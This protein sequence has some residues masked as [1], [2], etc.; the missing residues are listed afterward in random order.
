MTGSIGPVVYVLIQ[1]IKLS[2]QD[3]T[4]L[5]KSI[6]GNRNASVDVLRERHSFTN[7]SRKKKFDR[8][9]MIAH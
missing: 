3:P 8:I 6:Q 1:M 9:K 2:V 5:V 4:H 7:V